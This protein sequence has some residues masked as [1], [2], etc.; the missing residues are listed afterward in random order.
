MPP[1]FK[2]NLDKLYENIRN[3]KKKI[4]NQGASELLGYK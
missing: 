4:E 2:M 3:E 1:L